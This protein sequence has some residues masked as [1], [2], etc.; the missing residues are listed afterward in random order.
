MDVELPLDEGDCSEE[1]ATTAA[2]HQ[3]YTALLRTLHNAMRDSDATRD[4][5]VLRSLIRDLCQENPAEEGRPFVPRHEGFYQQIRRNQ[6]SSLSQS[7]T[8]SGEDV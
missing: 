7:P 2:H 1:S 4:S 8:L 3:N 5:P 6:D